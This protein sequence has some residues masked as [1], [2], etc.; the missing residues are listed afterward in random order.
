MACRSCNADRGQPCKWNGSAGTSHMPR[1][2]LAMIW[3]FDNPCPA[4]GWDRIP[5]LWVAEDKAI[6]MQNA[7]AAE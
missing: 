2:Q 6:P 3:H 7:E 5:H 4:I 1:R